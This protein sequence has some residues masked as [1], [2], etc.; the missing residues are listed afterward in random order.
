MAKL[1]EHRPRHGSNEDQSRDPQD[2]IGDIQPERLE[3]EP[4]EHGVP[5]SATLE[6]RETQAAATQVRVGG[7]CMYSK[8]PFSFSNCHSRVA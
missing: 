6:R 7:R 4:C 3:N 8:F 2:S 1:L 5:L